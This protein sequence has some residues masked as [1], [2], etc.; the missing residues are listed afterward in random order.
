MDSAGNLY[1]ITAPRGSAHGAGTIFKINPTGTETIL[2][3]FCAGC[4]GG[5]SPYDPPAGLIIDSAGSLYG[6]T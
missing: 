4:G 3:T 1:G 5:M 6:T 2:F